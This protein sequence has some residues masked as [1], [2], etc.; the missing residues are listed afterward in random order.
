MLSEERIIKACMKNDKQAQKLLYDK[1]AATLLGI[2]MRYAQSKDEA[3]D[4]VQD[5]FCKILMRI[6]Q[7]KG[8]GSFVG[9]IKRILINT[10]ITNF[11]KNE[12]HYYHN[13]ISELGD[14]YLDKDQID[15]ADF[16]MSELLKVI[17]ALPEGY[18]MVFNLYAIEGYKHK[19]IAEMLNIEE[20]TSKSQ[21]SRARK[22][23]QKELTKLAE[24]KEIF[25]QLADGK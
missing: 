12:K 21:F 3:E 10:A 8:S 1:Y 14:Y 4:I 16:Q 6:K 19:E 20:S 23:V 7:Y 17:N 2:A 5:A 11:K 15:D 18:K 24:T 25:L 9:W 22:I 13:D